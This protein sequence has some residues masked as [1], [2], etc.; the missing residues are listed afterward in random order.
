MTNVRRS[1]MCLLGLLLV[2]TVARAG[3]S[4]WWFLGPD[5]TMSSG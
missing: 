5:G 4:T 1:I 3:T 2:A